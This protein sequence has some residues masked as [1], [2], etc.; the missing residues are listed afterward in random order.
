VAS[1]AFA[2][3]LG[4]WLSDQRVGR[5]EVIAA[6]ALLAGLAAF[7]VVAD[8]GGG[9]TSAP[10]GAWLV[11]AA[12]CGGPCVALTLLAPR[13]PGH[14]RA[15]LL[16]AAAGILFA[17]SAALTD[18]VVNE[19][20]NGLL[21]VITT[22]PLYGLVAVGY[23]SMTLNQMSLDAGALAATVATSTALDPI[24]SVLLGLTLFKESISA[25]PIE[26]L[27]ILLALVVVVGAMIVLARD[28]AQPPSSM[29]SA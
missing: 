15:A 19:L 29:A 12:A 8:P 25:G 7:V 5:R 18:T 28:Q 20:S 17:L 24:A 16:G 21:T 4:A 13:V 3:P 9:R 2:L 6:A 11:A 10:L 27:V 23:V 14:R 1:V 22:W 26:V